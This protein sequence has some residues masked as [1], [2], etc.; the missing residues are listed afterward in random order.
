MTVRIPEELTR[1]HRLVSWFELP[2]WLPEAARAGKACV[3]CAGP[4]DATVVELAPSATLPRPGLH[5]LLRGPARLVHHLVRLAQAL[6]RLH[7]C[8]QQT[9]LV[10]H[11]RR[12]LHEQTMPPIDRKPVCLSCPAPLLATELVAPVRWEGTDGFNLGYAHLRC[13]SRRAS[14]T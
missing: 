4:V 7:P 12:L 3:W 14:V 5:A 10:G 13:L 8:K 11:G 1:L 2:R 9:C 6:L